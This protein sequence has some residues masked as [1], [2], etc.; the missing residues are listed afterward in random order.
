MPQISWPAQYPLLPY[1]LALAAAIA[2]GI[3]GQLLLKAGSVGAQST[4]AQF[5]RVPTVIGLGFYA[6]SAVFY[7][8][9][10]QRIPVSLAFP[11]VSISYAVI[12]LLGYLLWSE[13]VGWSQVAG[14]VLICTGVVLLYRV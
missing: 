9:A 11:S 7:V 2:G 12:A 14:I 5:M 3:G 10:L 13:P 1:Y 4:I 6:F 8:I